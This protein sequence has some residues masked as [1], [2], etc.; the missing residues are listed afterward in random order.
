MK[1]EKVLDRLNSLEKNS[2]LKIV[3]NIISSKPSNFK[4]IEIILSESEKGIKNA[5]NVNISRVFALIDQ[6]F[7]AQV[8]E[9]FGTITSQL[10]VF[11]DII[12]KDGFSVVSRDWFNKLY[13][14]EIRFLKE[15]LKD[16]NDL[17]EGKKTGIDICRLRDYKI[18]SACI[19]TAY[20]NDRLNNQEGKITSDE[21]SIL[22]TLSKSLDLSQEE[23]KLINYSIIPFKKLEIDEVINYLRNI[24]IIFYSKKNHLIYVPDEIKFILRNIREKEVADKYLRRILNL[25]KDPQINN[26]CRKHNIDLKL[27]RDEKI[28]KILKEGI[29]ITNILSHDLFRE[30]ITLTEKK[31]FINELVNKGLN[32][33]P[34]LKGVTIEDKI[35]HL[36]Q[37]FNELE[38]D[39]RIGIT[40]DGYNSLLTDLV[41]NFPKLNIIVKEAFDLESENVLNGEFLLESGIK[42][43]DIIDLLPET[44]LLNFC[45]WKNIKTRGNTLINILEAYKDTQN[46]LLENFALIGHRDFNALKENGIFI[47]ESELGVKFEDLTK[48]IFAK[49]G[50]NVDEPLRKKLN[51]NKDLVDIVLNLGQNEI[52][53]VECKTKKES[54][55]NKFSSV[56]R[57]IK[58]YFNL[59]NT[60]GLKVVKSLLI[61]PEFSDDFISDCELEYE[62]NLSLITATSLL[63]ILKG[64]QKS[65]HEKL[66]Y[67]L[68]M[69]DVLIKEDRILKAL[70][71]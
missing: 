13:E 36:I 63:N 14:R 26:I 1:L 8:K 35:N 28:R 15:G 34:Y 50:F 41:V 59:A 11:V 12:I 48:I 10:D 7:L 31:S 16:F 53:I 27:S 5:D 21:Q 4:K 38:K 69:R 9:E 52:I 3:D 22:I 6:E 18:Y 2:F 43:S 55:Y 40:I 56:S 32:I 65:K 51:T 44:E 42:P 71:K 66:P 62:L 33:S 57:Q 46:I 39:D 58:S 61:A 30:N 29:P 49:L 37:Y 47:K 60:N 70:E 45:K 20:S 19:K 17:L 64:L 24:G 25:L 67:N 23:I 68:L 54:G